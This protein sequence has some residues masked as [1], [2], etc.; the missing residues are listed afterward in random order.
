MRFR[1]VLAAAAAAA[2]LSI[3][4]VRA[5]DMSIVFGDTGNGLQILRE[6]LDIFEK[7]TGNKVTIVPMPSSTTDQFAQ[8]KLW[9]AAGNTDIDVYQT[10]VIWAPQLADQ[11]P[12]PDRGD[13]GRD[14]PTI[15]RRSSNRRPST[16]SWSR[17]RSSPTRRRSTTARTCSTSTA[18]RC[19][20]P[21]RSWPP[22]RRRSWTR[23]APRATP[24]IWGYRLPG[25]R[26]RGPDLQRARM[27]E[28]ERRRP[29]HRA[30]RH[31][32]RSTTSKRSRRSRWP[33]AGSGRSRPPA[34]SPTGGGVARRLA[35]R[36]R[37]L[38]AQLALCLCARQ[39]RRPPDQGQVRRD[40][41]ARRAGEGD[42]LGRDAR[43]LEPRGVANIRRTPEAAI[44]LVK[45]DRLGRDAEAAGAIKARNLPTIQ[46]LYDDR[47]HRQGAADHPA[48]EGR[49]PQRGAA[50]VG[51]GQGATT[52]CPQQVLDGGAQDAVG[53]QARRPT[54]LPISRST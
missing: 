2:A 24:D 41:A 39:R 35:D 26:L 7:N 43:R 34:C 12:R 4:P 9:L 16:A 18:P 54:T 45:F 25:Q 50:A 53:R 10:D 51:A 20:P 1:L 32:L 29:D 46:A 47:R 14:R 33:R 40:A 23:S 19:R 5:A 37:G 48:L 52:R 49:L 30:R 17:C 3:A 11:L 42:T 21:G 31:D 13:E 22:P 36:Q 44:E 15:S 38:H 28:V 27:G 8:Y 6:M